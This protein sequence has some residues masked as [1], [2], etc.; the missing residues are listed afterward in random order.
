MPPAKPNG[1]GSL[2]RG[3]TS[4]RKVC[5]GQ[6]LWAEAGRATER[7]ALSAEPEANKAEFATTR[8]A[9]PGAFLSHPTQTSEAFAEEEDEHRNE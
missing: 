7:Y 9:S 2:G 1:V 4:Y 5:R 8:W 3:L 6:F